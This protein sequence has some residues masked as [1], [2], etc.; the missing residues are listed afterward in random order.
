MGTTVDGD[1]FARWTVEV[2]NNFARRPIAPT[3]HNYRDAC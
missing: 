2:G 1:N 3:V